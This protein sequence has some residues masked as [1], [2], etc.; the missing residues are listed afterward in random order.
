MKHIVNLCIELGLTGPSLRPKRRI[1]VSFQLVQDWRE[2]SEGVT[3]YLHYCHGWRIPTNRLNYL[4]TIRDT[5]RVLLLN[6]NSSNDNK[7]GTCLTHSCSRL[8]IQQTFRRFKQTL[9]TLPPTL[10]SL[11][12][13]LPL[14][15]SLRTK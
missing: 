1:S 3:F 6:R 10:T 15:P 9:F 2:V 4:Y 14:L 13:F 12:S 11:L 5:Y 7:G 8:P